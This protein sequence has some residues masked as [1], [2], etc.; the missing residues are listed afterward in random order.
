MGILEIIGIVAA[1]YLIGAYLV[2]VLAVRFDFENTSSTGNYS[3]VLWLGA[4]WP[5]LLVLIVVFG[6]IVFIA[7]NKNQIAERIFFA[8]RRPMMDD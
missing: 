4:L 5:L 6:P 7:D 8:P 2:C 1:I 3:N